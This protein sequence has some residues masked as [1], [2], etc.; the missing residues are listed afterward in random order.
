MKYKCH[1]CYHIVDQDPCPL[2][3]SDVEEMCEN[4]HVCTCK[5]DIHDGIHYCE[6]CG[7]PVCPCGAHDTLALSRI[8]GY[9]LE[10][11]SKG[12]GW[13][14]GKKSGPIS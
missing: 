13:N 7:D 1:I 11:G 2:C 6:K 9:I 14:Q 4:D 5:E 10:V 12:H 3:G 8:T